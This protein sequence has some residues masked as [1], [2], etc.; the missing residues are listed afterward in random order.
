MGR[1]K[2]QSEAFTY[3]FATMYRSLR[4]KVWAAAGPRNA[5]L[6]ATAS[7]PLIIDIDASLVHVHSE[8]QNNAGT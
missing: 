4:S 5:A 8:K 3:G 7:N 1:I 6:L 2:D